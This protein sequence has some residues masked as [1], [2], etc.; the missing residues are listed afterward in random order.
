MEIDLWVI[1]QD[2]LQSFHVEFGHEELQVRLLVDITAT[3]APSKNFVIRRDA[4]HV[5]LTVDGK[6]A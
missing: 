2:S 4:I 5:R 1:L 6:K 3:S